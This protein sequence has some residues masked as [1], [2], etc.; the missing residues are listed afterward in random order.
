MGSLSLGSKVE[1]RHEVDEVIVLAI[2]AVAE[3][4]TDE[5]AGEAAEP[6]VIT[7]GKK[8]EEE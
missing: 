4:I 7:K 3:E 1:V 5:T 6:E 8:E 2:S